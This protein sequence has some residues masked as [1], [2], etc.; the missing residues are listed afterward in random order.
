MKGDNQPLV[1]ASHHRHNSRGGEEASLGGDSS[2]F[3][4][5]D[6]VHSE[7]VGNGDS[8]RMEFKGGSE[9]PTSN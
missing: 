7:P 8:V 5:A 2:D 6:V 4:L 9:S 3:A 1:V